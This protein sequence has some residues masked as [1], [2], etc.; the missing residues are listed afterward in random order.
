MFTRRGEASLEGVGKAAVTI[1]RSLV[2]GSWRGAVES[3]SSLV[4]PSLSSESLVSS[5]ETVGHPRVTSARL[6]PP[7]DTLFVV[8]SPEQRDRRRQ[9]L[10]RLGG[11][12]VEAPLGDP[13]SRDPVVL[14]RRDVVDRLCDDGTRAVPVRLALGRLAELL[15]LKRSVGVYWAQAETHCVG[16]STHSRRGYRAEVLGPP[17]KLLWFVLT[18]A[19]R[20]DRSRVQRFDPVEVRTQPG[21]GF[22][23]LAPLSLLALGVALAAHDP[24]TF[25][26]G[27]HRSWRST[28]AGVACACSLVAAMMFGVSAHQRVT[29]LKRQL[30]HEKTELERLRFEVDSARQFAARSKPSGANR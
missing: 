26:T 21:D 2:G 9:K 15:A 1:E 22:P 16:W 14:C 11:E 18:P 20:E 7:G 13:R 29:T 4:G 5:T 17:A 25:P 27:S 23:K 10:A 6:I 19:T 8:G 24:G 28:A 30:A 12:L 3:E